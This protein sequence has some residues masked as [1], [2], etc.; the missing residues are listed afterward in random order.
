LSK[1]LIIFIKNTKKW[2]ECIKSYALG[3]IETNVLSEKMENNQII[4]YICG[5]FLLKSGIEETNFRAN[6]KTNS[7]D[8]WITLNCI[9]EYQRET[10]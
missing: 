9:S 3:T 6:V 1:S 7:I 4:S 2:I 8:G 10:N 5:S